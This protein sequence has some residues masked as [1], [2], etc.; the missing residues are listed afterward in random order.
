VTFNKHGREHNELV[1]QGWHSQFLLMIDHEFLQRKTTA[2]MNM[3]FN[4][5]FLHYLPSRATN[6]Y[7]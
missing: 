3:A 7:K 1:K 4:I 6:D 2:K 5:L